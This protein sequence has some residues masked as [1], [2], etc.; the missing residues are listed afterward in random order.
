MDVA[1]KHKKHL[2]GAK[3]T[4]YRDELWPGHR[5]RFLEGGRDFSLLHSIQISSRALPASFCAADTT[6]DSFPGV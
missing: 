3:I 4:L 2:F 6:E 5:L 1:Y